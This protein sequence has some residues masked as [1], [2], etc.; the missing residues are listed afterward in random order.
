LGEVESHLFASGLTLTLSF[1]ISLIYTHLILG[2]LLLKN[3][4]F[5]ITE[6]EVIKYFFSD[7]KV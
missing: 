7:V 2:S 3:V 1:D 6:A 5:K 4:D